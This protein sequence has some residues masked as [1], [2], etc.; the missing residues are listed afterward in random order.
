MINFIQ[1][2]DSKVR[3]SPP[4]HK[5][6]FKA[7]ECIFLGLLFLFTTFHEINSDTPKYFSHI[8]KIFF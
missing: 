5:L 6:K 2:S 8:M 4:L 7:L 3:V 1:V